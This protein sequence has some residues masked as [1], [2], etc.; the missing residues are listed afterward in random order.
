M[1]DVKIVRAL[2]AANAALTAV[3]PGLRIFAGRIPQGAALPAICV[4]TVSSVERHRV[5]DAGGVILV[6]SRTQVTV[7][8]TSYPVQKDVIR[9][10]GLAIKGGRRVVGGVTVADIQRDIVG[11]DLS[12]PAT[13]LYQQSRDFRVKYFQ[14]L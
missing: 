9:L 8:S 7:Q 3:V 6:T 10:I 14:P 1:S 11:P 12:D 2:L 5:K 13:E 4:N